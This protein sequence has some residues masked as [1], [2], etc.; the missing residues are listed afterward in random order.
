ME[1]GTQGWRLGQE[2]IL[3]AS[4]KAPPPPTHS[5]GCCRGLGASNQRVSRHML[6][7]WV[8]KRLVGHVAINHCIFVMRYPTQ[9]EP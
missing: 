8:F 4:S 7:L 1:A 5:P 3:G 9:G 2:E 6:G